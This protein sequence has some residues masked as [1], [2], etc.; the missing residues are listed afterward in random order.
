MA[1]GARLEIVLGVKAL[2]GSNPASSATDQ[3]KRRC[4]EPMG[5]GRHCHWE[6]S[7][8]SRLMTIRCRCSLMILRS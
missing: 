2:A 6:W 5:C 1:Y 4:F 7:A 3:H 8:S